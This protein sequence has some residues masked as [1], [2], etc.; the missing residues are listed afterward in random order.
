M[1]DRN[2]DDERDDQKREAE[3]G[4]QGGRRNSGQ[5]SGD[6]GGRQETGGQGGGQRV[7][8]YMFDEKGWISLIS[9]LLRAPPTFCACETEIGL[10]GNESSNLRDWSERSRDLVL[11][12]DA[13]RLLPVLGASTTYGLPY[14]WSRMTIDISDA[15]LGRCMPETARPVG[16]TI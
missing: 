16:V 8:K 12:L 4:G 6:Q 11:L 1:A 14:F 10:S 15:A 5:G 13:G 2:R 9:F 7:D 3:D